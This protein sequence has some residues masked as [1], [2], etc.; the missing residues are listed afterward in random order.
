MTT[1]A[2]GSSLPCPNPGCPNI[3]DQSAGVGR[4]RQY[5]SEACGRAYRKL[6]SSQPET[7][8]ID[9]YAVQVA[10]QAAHHLQDI[11]RLVR[12][13]QALNVLE[14]ITESQL[15]TGDLTAAVVQQ[16]RA[17]KHKAADIA[18]AM[19]I[20][21]DKLSRD[22]S[23]EACARRQDRRQRKATPSAPRSRKPPSPRG[24]PGGRGRAGGADGRPG[25]ATPDDPGTTLANALAHL[26]RAS[27]KTLRV[28]GGESQVTASYLCRVLAGERLPSWTVTHQLGL[29]YGADPADLRPLWEAARGYEMT[30]P[31]TLHAALRGL[32]LS[33]ACPT[34]SAIRTL[35]R[36]G[37]S[38]ADIR[39]MLDGS[40]VPEWERV[41][42]L[43]EALRGR[44]DTIR[45]LWHM[46]KLA[47]DAGRPPHAPASTGPHRLPAQA[48]G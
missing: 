23:A 33:A 37:L 43:V 47:A 40:R 42:Q 45:P 44:A 1:K 17:R 24:K 2:S 48:F 20:S 19:N 36:D 6:R 30:A 16:A 22:Y 14:K 38:V 27:G 32:H 18:G 10:E 46:A 4:P 11:V 41:G 3:V 9:D 29:A 34:Y 35:S 7:A 8:D 13:G 15:M 28:A 25:L 5:C 26:H 39:G 21:V 12:D 31:L